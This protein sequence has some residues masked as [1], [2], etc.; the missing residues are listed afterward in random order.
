MRTSLVSIITV[1][2]LFCFIVILVFVRGLYI[3]S[4]YNEFRLNIP[5]SISDLSTGDILFFTGHRWSSIITK[6]FLDTN[7]Y[8][9]GI[10]FEDSTGVFTGVKGTMCVY[11]LNMKKNRVALYPLLQRLAKLSCTSVLCRQLSHS[12][13]LERQIELNLYILKKMSEK[14]DDID[15]YSSVIRKYILSIPPP[16]EVS[17]T[18]GDYAVSF[19]KNAGIWDV[20]DDGINATVVTLLKD[21]CPVG[22][23]C[24]APPRRI[25]ELCRS[26][27]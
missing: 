25:A 26:Y 14:I 4:Q 3:D 7:Y 17:H 9:I 22:L 19:L 10:V 15:Y 6:G 16:P 18:C 23:G 21:R 11:E 12:I 24:I 27:Q 2:F 13:T 1:S 5:V 8:H 20:N